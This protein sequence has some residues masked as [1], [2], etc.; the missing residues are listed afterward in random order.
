MWGP[1]APL[2]A[3]L[4]LGL[5]AAGGRPVGLDKVRLDTRNLT[6]TLSTRLQRLQLFPLGVQIRGLGA[7]LEGP[8][9]PLGLGAMA[10]RLQL[11]QRLLGALPG[12]GVATDLETLRHLLGAMGAL[13]RCPPRRRPPRAPPRAPRHGRGA[14]H[15]GGGHPGPAAPL[16]RGAGAGARGGGHGVLT[17]DVGGTQVVNGGDM[18]GGTRGVN[19]GIWRD[20]GGTWG[21]NGGTWGDPSC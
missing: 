14:P 7:L 16:P 2:W 21:V 11:F 20:M 4:C 15:R 1:A 12:G 13:L 9:P 5:P 10:Q 18:E 19:G 6:R 3:L 8:P 17:G